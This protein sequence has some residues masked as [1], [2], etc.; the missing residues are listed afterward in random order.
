MISLGAAACGDRLNTVFDDYGRSVSVV[1]TQEGIEGPIVVEVGQFDQT[2]K[3]VPIAEGTGEPLVQS[4]L[5]GAGASSLYGGLV[6]PPTTNINASGGSGGG[7][8]TGSTG[9]GSAPGGSGQGGGIVNVNSSATSAARGGQATGGTASGGTGGNPTS[10]A[11]GQGGLGGNV[12]GG[13]GGQGGTAVAA[14]ANTNN[15]TSS[16]SGAG[17]N[18]QGNCQ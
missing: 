1:H 4:L 5:R 8:G 17:G 12:T 10:S 3:F 15:A 9:I 7:A 2:G 11:T 18:C 6:R 16:T 13:V 14:P